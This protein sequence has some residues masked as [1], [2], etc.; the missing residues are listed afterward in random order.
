VAERASE[1]LRR[2]GA[3]VAGIALLGTKDEG[4]LSKYFAP[5]PAIKNKRLPNL[6]KAFLRSSIWWR[7]LGSGRGR[8][9]ATVTAPSTDS[10]PRE[11]SRLRTDHDIAAESPQRDRHEESHKE[12]H[13]D[14]KQG[15][16]RSDERREPARVD[17]PRDPLGPASGPGEPSPQD[18]GMRERSPEPGPGGEP[19]GDIPT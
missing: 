5:S 1:H 16:Q 3:N 11:A 9:V 7:Q 8:S 2:L 14:Q 4:P 12:V 15:P 13:D 10:S 6:R 18:D 17:D 19:M